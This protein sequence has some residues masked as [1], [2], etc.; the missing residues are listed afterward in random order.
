MNN[1][2][3]ARIAKLGEKIDALR[4][5]LEE[6]TQEEQDY[7]DNMPDSLQGGEKGEKAQA[8]ID[9][10]ESAC[11]DLESVGDLLNEATE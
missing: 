1:E 3:R 9:N 5:E 6:I 8:A 11:S 2:R 4:Q 10:L 7:L